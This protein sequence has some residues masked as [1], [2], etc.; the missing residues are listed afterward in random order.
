SGNFLIMAVVS[1]GV[2][3]LVG[4]ATVILT[5]RLSAGCAVEAGV[6]PVRGAAARGC[7]ASTSR[8]TLRE[9]RGPSMRTILWFVLRPD[10]QGQ[11][12]CSRL[13][14]GGPATQ[15]IAVRYS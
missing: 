8:R 4:N 2:C 10:F 9:S 14:E 12:L 13:G 11:S 3:V 15:G 6:K 5:P 7:A 1:C